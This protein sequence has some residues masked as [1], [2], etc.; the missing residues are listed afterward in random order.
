MSTDLTKIFTYIQSLLS[1]P[2]FGKITITLSAHDSEVQSI[3]VKHVPMDGL[4]IEES[5]DKMN[6]N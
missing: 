6:F 5:V 4:E 2:F 1:R 3:K